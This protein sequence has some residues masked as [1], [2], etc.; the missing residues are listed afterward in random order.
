MAVDFKKIFIFHQFTRRNYKENI[1]FE[2]CQLDSYTNNLTLLG[3]DYGHRNGGHND[4]I[5]SS[6]DPNG[7]RSLCKNKVRMDRVQHFY[8]R[9]WRSYAERKIEKYVNDKTIGGK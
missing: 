7:L 6:D 4:G 8:Q 1:T 2:A 9:P 3:M 5:R